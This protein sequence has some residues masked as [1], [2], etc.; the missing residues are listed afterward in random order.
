[1][2]NKM[3]ISCR[4]DNSQH[5]FTLMILKFHLPVLGNIGLAVCSATVLLVRII[6][7]TNIKSHPKSCFN[8]VLHTPHLCPRKFC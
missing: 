4:L 8:L 6:I 1:M 2:I 5:P 7:T 3:K